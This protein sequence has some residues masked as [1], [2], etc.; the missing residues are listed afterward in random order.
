MH[1]AT[2]YLKFTALKTTPRSNNFKFIVVF[3]STCTFIQRSFY[4]HVGLLVKLN[5]NKVDQYNTHTGMLFNF[6]LIPVAGFNFA[7]DIML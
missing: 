5:S 6:D 1:F 3:R 4:A 2:I 7:A